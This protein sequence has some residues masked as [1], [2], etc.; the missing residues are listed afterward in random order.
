M[1]K[2][3]LK[4]LLIGIA[5]GCIFFVGNIIFH[6]LTNSG[7]LQYFFSNFTAYA[8]GFVFLGIG[9]FGGAFVY[10]IERLRFA[11]KSVIHI[12]VGM[13]VFI[14]VGF[15]LNWLTLE[16]SPTLIINIVIN[17][18]L[19]LAIWT[20]LYIRDKKEIQRINR[21]LAERDSAKPLDTE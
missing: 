13:G 8:I 17:L 14:I 4:Y 12:S 1:V 5:V 7:Q 16:N 9:F 19:L 6:D 15:R 21:A 11:L 3:I 10:E 20:V 2:L 18:S